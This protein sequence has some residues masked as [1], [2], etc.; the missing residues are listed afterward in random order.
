MRYPHAGHQLLV[1]VHGCR[2]PLLGRCA[3]DG[4]KPAATAGA[5]MRASVGDVPVVPGGERRVGL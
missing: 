5:V 4:G 1:P 2:Q 3:G